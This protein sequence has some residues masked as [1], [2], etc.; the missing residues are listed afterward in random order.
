MTSS[1]IEQLEEIE[2]NLI[3]T[4]RFMNEHPDLKIAKFDFTLHQIALLDRVL[5]MRIMEEKL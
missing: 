5:T 2:R 3:N 1:E 4:F